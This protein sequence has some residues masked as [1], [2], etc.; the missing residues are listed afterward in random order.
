M[1]MGS[2]EEGEEKTNGE[3]R[4]EAY[5][6]PSVKQIANENLL[7]DSGNSNWGSIT[8]QRDGEGLEVGGDVCMCCAVLSHP[9]MSDSFQPY[10]LQPAEF[11]C[12]WK[13]PGENSGVSSLSLLQGIFLTQKLNQG[14]LHCRQILYQ[15]SYQYS[16][17]KMCC[18][19]LS[20]SVMSDS[21]RAHGLQP[22]RLLCPW[23]F[24][25]QECWSG[26]PYNVLV[27]IVQ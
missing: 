6:L 12:P 1:D 10:R 13:S 23:G 26:V 9:V 7:Y 17:L 4:M 3:S 11:L 19:V 16:Q 22:A 2:G 14:L 21:L 5:A 27:S 25:R 24:S 8:T 18:A 15:L 20:H